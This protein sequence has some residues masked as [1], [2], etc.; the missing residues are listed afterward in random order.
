MSLVIKRSGFDDP[1][2]GFAIGVTTNTADGSAVARQVYQPCS[3]RP[4]NSYTE[5]ATG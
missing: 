3:K 1:K 5:Q 2:T 4:L